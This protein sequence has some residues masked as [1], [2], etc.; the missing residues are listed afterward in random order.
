MTEGESITWSWVVTHSGDYGDVVTNIAEY[1]HL[2]SGQSS[3][4]DAAFTVLSGGACY[5]P[6]V[7]KGATP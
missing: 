7:R 1:S 6:V 4:A 3:S 5:L 2:A